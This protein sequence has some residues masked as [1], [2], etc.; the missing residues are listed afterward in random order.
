MKIELS[1]K[2]KE[3]DQKGVEINDELI[4]LNDIRI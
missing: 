2:L 1:L 4:Q 3:C